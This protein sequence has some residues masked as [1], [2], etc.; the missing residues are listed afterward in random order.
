VLHTLRGSGEVGDA[1]RFSGTLHSAAE[2]AGGVAPPADAVFEPLA[3]AVAALQSKAAGAVLE[4]GSTPRTQQKQPDASKLASGASAANMASARTLREDGLTSS[5]G[6]AG[7]V[8]FV[9]AA[10]GVAGSADALLRRPSVH[11]HV[12]KAGVTD[13]RAWQS[14]HSDARLDSF[15]GWR[16]NRTRAG[17]PGAASA[18]S[19]TCAAAD[20]PPLPFPGCHV[21]INHKYKYIY[22]RSP[23]AASTSIVNVLGECNN[24]A[25]AGHNASSCMVRSA[26]S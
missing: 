12:A 25:T 1:W 5:A 15:L 9:S 14:E 26:V 3:A 4:M 16:L 11:G 19:Y 10:V 13:L 23:K 7:G 20:H 24:V 17:G 6:A 8:P 21:F 22:I 18:D 2:Q